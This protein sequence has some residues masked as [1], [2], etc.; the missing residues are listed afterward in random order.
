MPAYK[1]EKKDNWYVA[2]YFTDWQ[3]KKVKKLKRGF[4]TKKEALTWE[5]EFLQQ[6]SADLNMKFE[7]F[8]EI[9]SNDMKARLKESTWL[10]KEHIIETKILPHFKDKPINEIQP[11]DVIQWQNLMMKSEKSDGEAYSPVYLRTLGS[12]LSAIFNH[13]VRFYDL[14]SNP[15]QKAGQM[16][17]KKGQEV[18]FWTKEEYLLFADVMR[19]KPLSYYAYQMLYWTGLRMGELLALTSKDFDFKQKTVTVSK[20]YQRIKGKDLITSPKTE[21]SNRTISMPDFLCEEMEEFITSHYDLQ[22]TDRIFPITKSYLHSEMK[23]GCKVS[24]VKQIKVHAT[25]HSHVSLLIE[26]GFSVVAIAKRVGHES[27][28]I[29]YQYA[30]LFPN[31]ERAIADQLTMED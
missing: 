2:F 28:N 1:D 3:G 29:T 7:K 16:G 31:T 4:V 18:E 14:K 10:T 25:R 20:S 15:V 24:G 21:K 26:M 27:E 23:R 17:K 9:Y 11:K 13:A 8:V 5:R 19:D 30:H 12:Q 6:Q 22:D